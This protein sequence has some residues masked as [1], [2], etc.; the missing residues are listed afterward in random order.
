MKSC[1]T[2]LLYVLLAVPAG[3]SA[4]SIIPFKHLGEAL[5]A[6]EAVVLARFDA[7]V[8][9]PDG[10]STFFDARMRTLNVV[11]GAL[12]P[13]EVFPLRRYSHRQGEYT[14][15]I[16]GD[17]IPEAGKTYLLFLA[18]TGDVWRPV[19]LSYYVF[20]AKEKDGDEFLVPLDAMAGIELVARKDGAIPEAPG[21]YHMEALMQTLTQ[22]YTGEKQVWNAGAAL[23]AYAP[24]DFPQERAL[25]AGCDFS[26]SGSPLARW[27][28]AAVQVYFEPTNAPSG[29]SSILDAILGSM[30]GNY[31]G[32][33]PTNGG[34]ASFSPNCTDNTVTGQDF[35][36]FMLGLNGTQG[37]LIFFDDPCNQ[38]PNL[39]GCAGTLAIGGGYTSSTTH[40][41]KGDTWNNALLGFIVVNN[42]VFPACLDQ[43]EYEIMLTHEMTHT[44]RMD[45]LDAGTYPNQNMNPSCCNAINTKDIECM[46]YTYDL[47][48]P[49]KLTAFNVEALETRRV[50]VSWST[51]EEINNDYFTIEHSTDGLHF[52]QAYT[53]AANNGSALRRY[54]WI[55]PTPANGLNY[56]RLSQTD[57]DG[58]KTMLGLKA[59]SIE[60][61]A[62]FS[63]F[64]NPA[65]TATLTLLID[66]PAAFEG[67]M[68]ITDANGRVLYSA[69][70]SLEGGRSKIE[71]PVGALAPGAYWLRLR[72]GSM[73][74]TRRFFRN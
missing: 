20:E 23:S 64:P 38:I 14:I 30:N 54:E 45:H 68:E 57:L 29:F 74:Q 10:H 51:V 48:S 39:S 53:T 69:N 55:D 70:L 15:D 62:R 26:L 18:R 21:V 66:W 11:K 31:T 35:V 49:V 44:Y 28:N 16:A 73:A 17:F 25:P 50:S 63:V 40:S 13:G 22:Y 46:N 27:Q 59:V 7:L 67:V 65:S 12:T 8:E 42:G 34:S 58:T 47:T 9:T 36:D 6:S 4:S 3:I 41:Y 33:D 52:G 2:A 71:Q 43:A 37:T 61:E 72:D 5:E 56:Y 24:A 32:I 1:Y 19:T 60:G